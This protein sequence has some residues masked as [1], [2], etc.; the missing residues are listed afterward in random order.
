MEIPYGKERRKT[1]QM[2]SGC[3]HLQI[4]TQPQKLL[5]ISQQPEKKNGLDISPAKLARQMKRFLNPVDLR[6][7]HTH[8]EKEPEES[9]CKV[10]KKNLECNWT[11][12]L[13]LPIGTGG[14]RKCT[15]P[16]RGGVRCTLVFN[17]TIAKSQSE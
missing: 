4:I 3:L 11:N 14:G 8:L 10:K 6:I 2:M 7:S 15:S 1:T 5:N 17:C 12:L 9:V 16:H 13:K